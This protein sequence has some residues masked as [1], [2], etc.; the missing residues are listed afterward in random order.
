MGL[1]DRLQGPHLAT[2]HVIG[3]LLQGGVQ[4]PVEGAQL[5]EAE[6]VQGERKNQALQ[7]VRLNSLHKPSK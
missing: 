6:L 7:V 3:G 2:Q 1:V 4:L 5:D